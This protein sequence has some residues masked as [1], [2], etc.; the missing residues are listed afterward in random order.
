MESEGIVSNVGVSSE[1]PVMEPLMEPVLLSV[2][3]S[4]G[5]SPP[6]DMESLD[7]KLVYVDFSLS[8]LI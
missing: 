7:I 8:S 2:L 5:V 1:E 4:V 3:L 6:V